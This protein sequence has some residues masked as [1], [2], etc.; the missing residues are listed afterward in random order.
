L[1]PAPTTTYGATFDH[2]VLPGRTLVGVV[3]D[4]ETGK[5]LAGVEVRSSGPHAVATTDASG[6]YELP[7]SAKSKEYKLY[8]RPAER[9]LPYFNTQFRFEDTPGLGPLQA[10]LVLR[11]GIPLHLRVVD[12]ET[13]KSLPGAVVYYEPLFPNPNVRP[14]SSFGL[15]TPAYPQP[16]GS[17]LGVAWPGPAAICVRAAGDIRSLTDRFM[18]V[19]VDPRPFFNDKPDGKAQSFGDDKTLIVSLGGTPQPIPQSQFH[20]IVPINP[21]VDAPPLHLVIP[22][23]V[24]KTLTLEILGRDG[25]PLTGARVEDREARD[26]WGRPLKTSLFH[27]MGLNPLRPRSLVIEHE[28]EKLAAILVARGDERGAVRVRLRPWGSATGRLIVDGKPKPGARLRA[29][30]TT[31]DEPYA[32]HVGS[33]VPTDAEGHFVVDRLIEG[34]RYSLDVVDFIEPYDDVILGRTVRGATIQ[35]G[36]QVDLGDVSMLPL[37]QSQ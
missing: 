36:A 24:G 25:N 27:A 37:A 28:P 18:H 26:G 17:Y 35:A 16:D 11:R 8:V 12:G 5:P 9:G 21:A 23:E 1:A 3:T 7:G 20:K 33:I 30:G 19:P 4:R 22:L 32:G 10:D 2:M 6:R 13:G 34:L 15:F 31:D 14:E 29:V